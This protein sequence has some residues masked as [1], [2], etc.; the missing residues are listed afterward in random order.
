MFEEVPKR[1]IPF[2]ELFDGCRLPSRRAE[3]AVS[4]GAD[5]KASEKMAWLRHFHGT[6][7]D[8]VKSQRPADGAQQPHIHRQSD[9]PAPVVRPGSDAIRFPAFSPGPAGWTEPQNRN[10]DYGKGAAVG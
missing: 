6:N 9:G 2:V 5:G 3:A 4:A 8:D 10:G 7:E 1:A